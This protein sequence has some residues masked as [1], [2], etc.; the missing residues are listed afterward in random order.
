MGRLRAVTDIV[1]GDIAT[2][3]QGTAMPCGELRRKKIE[4]VPGQLPSGTIRDVEC[5]G[6]RRFHI[7]FEPNRDAEAVPGPPCE[8]NAHDAQDAV[9][10]PQRPVFLAGGARAM[11]IT[12]EPL[13]R[14]PGFVLGRIV[15]AAPYDRALRAIP[16]CQADNRP[17]EV[18]TF[19]VEGTPEADIKA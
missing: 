14:A 8:R 19:V 10:A 18:P 16:G 1:F 12:G 17:P 9:H 2:V 5:W 11:A 7:E 6:L 4:H 3:G 13:N 15:E